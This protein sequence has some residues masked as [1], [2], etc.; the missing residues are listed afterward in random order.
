M[1]ESS[2]EI[3]IQKKNPCNGKRL[4]YLTPKTYKKSSTNNISTAL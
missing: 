1:I 2:S 4:H 3:S